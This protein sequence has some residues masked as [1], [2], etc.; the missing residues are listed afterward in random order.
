MQPIH[1]ATPEQFREL[2]LPGPG[3]TGGR[4]GLHLE[5]KSE[6]GNVQ[7]TAGDIA[8]MANAE[9]GTILFGVREDRARRSVAESIYN[10][11]ERR[12]YQHI[13]QAIEAWM[14]GFAQVPATQRIEIGDQVVVAL[15]IFPSP[16]LVCVPRH[17]GSLAYPVRTIEDTRYLTHDEV[18]MRNATYSARA[19][20]IRLSEILA[21][22][23]ARG[24]TATEIT[25]HHIAP[26]GESELWST[27][28]GAST[29]HFVKLGEHGAWMR[30]KVKDREFMFQVP[31][32]WMDPGQIWEE[33]AADNT[34]RWAIKANAF[35]Q[36]QQIGNRIILTAH[37]NI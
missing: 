29:C 25:L 24:T 27:P 30:F 6:H 31:Y 5:Y 20:R 4:E 2:V 35:F 9:G 1:I 34:Y 37:P 7:D 19:T 14:S 17:D 26:N 13:H 23:R 28:D 15:H 16:G 33:P 11:D 12:T 21:D 18:T 36:Q 3:G 10:I 8:A 22:P 32:Q